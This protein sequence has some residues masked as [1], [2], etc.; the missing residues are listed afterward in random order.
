MMP[1]LCR[2]PVPGNPPQRLA[3]MAVLLLL[4][5]LP[6]AV[7]GAESAGADGADKKSAQTAPDVSPEAPR[8]ITS[9]HAYAAF[10]MAC[11]AEEA[12]N[13]DEAQKWLRSAAAFDA[14]AVR[15]WNRRK[16]K[17]RRGQVTFHGVQAAGKIHRPQSGRAAPDGRRGKQK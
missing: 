6:A 13:R 4:L 8:K 14:D 15:F 10:L 2:T 11:L 9:S 3:R 7:W 1:E 17:N 16:Q 12:G 5:H